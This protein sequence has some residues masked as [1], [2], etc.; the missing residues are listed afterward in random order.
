ML[1]SG[2]GPW[3]VLAGYPLALMGQAAYGPP[4]GAL[5][6]ELFR[7]ENRA[8]VAGWLAVAGVLGA[9]AGLLVFGLLWEVIGFA[10][11]ALVLFAPVGVL[12]WLYL[13]LP[14]T[15]HRELDD[16]TPAPRRGR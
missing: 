7:T 4:A 16:D 8:T 9:S 13:V 3:S 12:A 10:A 2:F 15:R 1:Y 11:T 14:E 6:A 5:D